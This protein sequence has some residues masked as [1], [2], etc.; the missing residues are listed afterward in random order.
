[1]F[2]KKIVPIALLLG[3]LFSLNAQAM[4]L[5]SPTVEN[6]KTLQNAQIFNGWGCTGK[7]ESPA[8]KWSDIPDGTK[9]FAVTMYDPDAPTGSGWWHWVMVDIP[10]SVNHLP[11]NVGMKGSK[12]LPKGAIQLRNDF[13]YDGFGGACPPEG[14]K[15]HNYQIT[16]YALNVP[17]LD[18]PVNASP[19]YAGFFIL[20]HKIAEARLT[21]PTNAR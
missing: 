12:D 5:S 6:G 16:V 17:K 14:A 7:N 3:G 15:P 19:A 18:I 2:A 8:L 21:A 13:G 11:E 20:Q 10:A 1:M 9:S 4:E